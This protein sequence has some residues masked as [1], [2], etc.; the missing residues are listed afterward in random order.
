[1]N[2]YRLFRNGWFSKHIP[3][4]CLIAACHALFSFSMLMR[5][6]LF[7]TGAIGGMIFL[8]AIAPLGRE[9]AFPCSLIMAAGLGL[10]L[11]KRNDYLWIRTLN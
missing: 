2:S 6:L 1:M 11:R 3:V 9:A 4:V 7:R 8:V 5:G 10:L